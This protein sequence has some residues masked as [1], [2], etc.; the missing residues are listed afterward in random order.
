MSRPLKKNCNF[1]TR[2]TIETNFAFSLTD[3]SSFK[4][5]SAALKNQTA[6]MLQD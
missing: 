3:N 4:S 6:P 1:P 5:Q 2:L